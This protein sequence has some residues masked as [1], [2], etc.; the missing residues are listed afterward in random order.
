MRTEED[1]GLGEG[2]DGADAGEG[3]EG[4]Q[5]GS[6][7]PWD[8]SDRDYSYEELLGECCGSTFN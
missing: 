6:G 7:L 1:V 5:A 8:G 4:A 2:G 3:T